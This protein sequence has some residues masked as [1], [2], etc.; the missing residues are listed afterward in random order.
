MSQAVRYEPRGSAG[1]I[2]VDNPAVNALSQAARQDRV[3]A[4]VAGRRTAL[5]PR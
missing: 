5:P 4:P 3:D 2:T 1:I